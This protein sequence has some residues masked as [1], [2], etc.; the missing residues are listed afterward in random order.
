[1]DLPGTRGWIRWR[2]ETAPWEPRWL[3]PCPEIK[4]KVNYKVCSTNMTKSS[5]PF[6]MHG[7]FSLISHNNWYQIFSFTISTVLINEW[8]SVHVQI[9]ITPCLD[10]GPA[11]ILEV[12]VRVEQEENA[13]FHSVDAHRVEVIG[14][15]WLAEN[16]RGP[17]GLKLWNVN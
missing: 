9:C 13:E 3:R 15:H 10:K 2:G 11:P 7:P 16:G 5:F 17:D 12:G 1:M 6:L 14:A 8:C 4:K